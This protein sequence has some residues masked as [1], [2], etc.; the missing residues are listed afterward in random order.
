MTHGVRGA[1]LRCVTGD[2]LEANAKWYA[3]FLRRVEVASVS[4][5]EHMLCL[6]DRARRVIAS[7][8]IDDIVK[9]RL[10]R[11]AF[12]NELFITTKRQQ[13][14]CKALP[15]D[16]SRQI[17]QAVIEH[18]RKRAAAPLAYKLAPKIESEDRGMAVLLADLISATKCLS[19]SEVETRI[20][21][22]KRL[23]DQ[24]DLYVLK[25]FSKETRAAF[26]RLS[27]LDDDKIEQTRRA[28]NQRYHRRTAAEP[29]AR[30]LRPQ[31]E[32]A[33]ER[34]AHRLS[35]K[36]YL[37]RSVADTMIADIKRLIDQ[38]DFDIHL[39]FNEETKAKLQ[40]LSDLVSGK[41][42]QARRTS[43]QQYVKHTA[44][45][46]AAANE[47]TLPVGL[48]E[49]QAIAVATDED[50]TLVLAGAGT[51]K[52]AV[53]IGKAAHLIFNQGAAPGEILVLAFNRKAVEEIRER[54]P[55]DLRDVDVHTFHS[56]GR[57]VLAQSTNRSPTI[58]RLAEDGSHRKNA[59]STLVNDMLQSS[60][61]REA[62]VNL[63]AFHRNDYRSPFD[64]KTRD[65]YLR[66]VRSTEL[67][68][69]SGHLVK[70]LEEVQVANFLSL[71][72]IDFEYEQPYQVDTASARHRQYQPDFFL[73]KYEIYIEHF[74]LDKEGNPPPCFVNYSEGVEWKRSIHER[75]GTT[76]I[77][78]YSWQCRNGTLQSALENDLRQCGIELSP[79]PTVDLLE[80]LRRYQESWL[81]S[82]ISTGIKHAKTGRVSRNK[83][84]S[85][86]DSVRSN[87]FLDVLEE[88]LD[89]Y[90]R[91]LGEER[92]V[93]FEDLI[94]QAAEHIGGGRWRVRHRYVLVDEFQDISA[95]RMALIGA[96]KRA[97]TAYFLVGDD[98][99]SIYRFSG[100]DVG[101]VRDCGNY[102]GYVCECLLSTTFR[103]GTGILNPSAAF[104]QRNPEQTQRRL[105][106]TST[107]ENHGITVVAEASQAAGIGAALEH[108]HRR[109]GTE[110]DSDVRMR[111]S[112]LALGRYRTSRAVAVDAWRRGGLQVEFSTIHSAKGR[113]ADYVLVLDLRNHQY[114]LPSQIE[115]DPLLELLLPPRRQPALPHA[116]ER[117]LFY[118]AVTRARRG[119]YLIAD[120][121]QP[122]P[123]VEELLT[124][125]PDI[126]R[127]GSGTLD[128]NEALTCARCGGRLVE[129]QSGKNLRCVNHPL[130][131]NLVPRCTACDKG[132][133]VIAAGRSVC[134]NEACTSPPKACPRCGNGILTRKSGPHGTFFG[135][136]EYWAVPS[137]EYTESIGDG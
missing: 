70:S 122:S 9:I 35:G 75:H 58:S 125:H 41:M 109:E 29:V 14:H 5:R 76:L 127:I 136:S 98:W 4:Y 137:C 82:L 135:C 78:T 103:Y 99:Q 59:I 37:R 65:E 1:K 50:V 105:S 28:S 107:A 42:E 8:P 112:V 36:K 114:G 92:A 85:A 94:N 113:E 69:L 46:I 97:G 132:H 77:E 96:L 38:C 79:V 21:R 110:T 60:R 116:E 55:A 40:R 71:N 16:R 67:R 131:R 64:F 108:I 7:I 120:D 104:V 57:H 30:E 81:G 10:I 25:S 45:L 51:G 22:I 118:V 24:C 87:A 32:D 47:N 124:N 74:A 129:S 89:R 18:H 117:R 61:H 33:H 6:R 19:R 126:P 130:C 115:D 100:S 88:T 2:T 72:G 68:T 91:L 52:T 106:T 20:D 63:L 133:V 80:Q 39:C 31:V 102:L 23:I 17:K 93:D 95:G 48:T 12:S 66:Y 34:V 15:K 44:R 27:D 119:V 54:L 13:W 83:L 121:E 101:L 62:L 49:E 134:T 26:H 53:I 43:N 90:Q 56:F 73:P 3:R 111:V 86:A 84:R 123:F 11:H 128:R